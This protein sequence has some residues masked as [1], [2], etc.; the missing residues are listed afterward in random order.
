MHALVEYLCVRLENKEEIP[1]F[2]AGVKDAALS[3]Q[4]LA[5][6]TARFPRGDA[7]LAA[8]AVFSLTST[9]LRDQK[10][11]TR[12]SLFELLSFLIETYSATL[13][14]DMGP[15]AFVEGLVAMSAFEKDPKCLRVLFQ[16]YQQISRTW[17]LNSDDFKEI[18]GSFSKY[19]PITFREDPPDPSI[20]NTK[21]L[22]FLI[23]GCF[24]SHDS[25]AAHAFTHLLE[26][27][28]TSQDTVTAYTKVSGSLLCS[29]IV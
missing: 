21:E 28:D 26:V 5:S 2:R 29:R 14:R 6:M 27:L 10:P 1:N 17:T 4:A 20:P 9:S 7:S 15:H 12:L 16:M 18:W 25:Y 11:A 23:E 24:T 8:K 19:W 13:T 3:L 22:N